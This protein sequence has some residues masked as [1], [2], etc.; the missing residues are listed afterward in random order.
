[1][2]WFVCLA[3][4]FS[5]FFRLNQTRTAY[6]SRN[7]VGS[8]FTL[9]CGKIFAQGAKK[10]CTKDTEL[11]VPSCGEIQQ[12]NDLHHFLLLLPLLLPRFLSLP[13]RSC[14]VVTQDD[15]HEES[16]NEKL[17]VMIMIFS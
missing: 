5:Y 3:I 8:P 11:W 10:A 1:M 17:R 12:R 16:A 2:Q 6:F 14:L 7:S 9:T 13:L 4:P 15:Q